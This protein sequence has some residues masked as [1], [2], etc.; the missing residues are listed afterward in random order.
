MCAQTVEVDVEQRHVGA[1]AGGHPRRVDAHRPP[2]DDHDI[3]RRH[4][5]DAAEQDAAPAVRLAQV[6]RA[7]EDGQPARHLAHRREQGEAP[8]RALDRLVR[9][10]DHLGPAQRRR[11]RRHGGQVEIGEED[12]P[13]PEPRVFLLDRLLDLEDQVGGGPDVVDR[14][15]LRADLGVFVVAN[16]AAAP[17]PRARRATRWPA[18]TSACTPAGVAATRCSPGLISRGTPM[19]MSGGYG[20]SR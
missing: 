8:V 12:L 16:A 15:E 10:G 19:T 2:A 20:P 14:R 6:V 13:A 5:G 17:A 9:D 18:S 3:G 1:Q 4:A 7:F 11:Q